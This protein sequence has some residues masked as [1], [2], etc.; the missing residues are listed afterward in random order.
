MQRFSSEVLLLSCFILFFIGKGFWPTSAKG[1][2]MIYGLQ[3]THLLFIQEK[4]VLYW[5]AISFDYTDSL[6]W[7]SKDRRNKDD[8]KWIFPTGEY[9]VKGIP[10]KWSFEFFMDS[11]LFGYIWSLYYQMHFS[12]INLQWYNFMQGTNF[13]CYVTFG[14]VLYVW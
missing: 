12:W 10:S 11:K 5:L 6:E 14:S 13:L 1:K 9:W 4:W 8:G 3:L 2:A 7:K